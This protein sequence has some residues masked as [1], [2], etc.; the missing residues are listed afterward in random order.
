MFLYVFVLFEENTDRRTAD[1]SFDGR[2]PKKE[3]ICAAV[4]FGTRLFFQEKL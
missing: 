3:M 2:N 4:I 1:R